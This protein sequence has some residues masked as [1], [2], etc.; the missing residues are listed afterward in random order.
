MTENSETTEISVSLPV[1]FY[2][3]RC[4]PSKAG[5]LFEPK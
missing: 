3:V 1:T 5:S 2:R 4:M